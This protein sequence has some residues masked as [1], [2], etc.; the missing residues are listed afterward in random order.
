MLIY[1]DREG[2][3]V[4]RLGILGSCLVA[5]FAF[6]ATLAS[7]AYAGEYGECVKVGKVGAAYAGAYLDKGCVQAASPEQITQ[8]RHNKYD[9][10]KVPSDTRFTGKTGSVVLK[11]TGGVMTCKH[12]EIAGEI[13]GW[14]KNTETINLEGCFLGEGR[15]DNCWSE[16]FPNTF[17]TITSFA[18][19]SYLIDHGTAGPGGH[20]PREG[21][22][23]DEL[24]S[25]ERRPYLVHWECVEN[26]EY[27]ISGTVSGVVTSSGKMGKTAKLSFGEG[28]GEQELI[29]EFSA[30][31]G[32]TWYGS[33]SVLLTT[34]AVVKFPSKV[35][36][37]PCDESGASSEGNGLPG[38]ENEE[39]PLPW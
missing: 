27:R 1:P 7:S 31:H 26:I 33:E 38:C 25:N 29:V 12:G 4:K 28:E 5:M 3:G 37:R 14:Q 35:E 18:L 17:S 8:G 6:G 13:L 10:Q 36:V 19:G 11:W 23:W 39:L 21:E 16:A 20:M 30:N 9:W 24:E 15:S 34:S 2:A 32:A 22:A